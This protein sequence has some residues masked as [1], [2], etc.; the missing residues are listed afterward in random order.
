MH[1]EPQLPAA[2]L[3]L[4]LVLLLAVLPLPPAATLLDPREPSLTAT[5][6]TAATLTN[7]VFPAGQTRRSPTMSFSR[8]SAHTSPT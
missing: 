1:A 8:A 3:L 2:A 4:V 6:A 7:A 5:T